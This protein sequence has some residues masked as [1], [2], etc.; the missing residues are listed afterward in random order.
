MA[1]KRPAKK[2]TGLQYTSAKDWA[3]KQ[4]SGDSGG[5]GASAITVPEGTTF[6]KLQ[7]S[8]EQPWVFLDILP[9]RVGAGNPYADEGMVHFER[10]YWRHFIPGADGGGRSAVCLARTFKEDCPICAHIQTLQ[11]SGHGEDKTTKGLFAKQRQLFNIMDAK[12]RSDG[13]V[14]WESSFHNFG[15]LLKKEMADPFSDRSGFFRLDTGSVV[16][17]RVEMHSYADNVKPYARID[18]IEFT[19]RSAPLPDT[20]LDK[21][22]CL[23]D[24]INHPTYDELAALISRPAA[25]AV[26][27]AVQAAPAELVGELE[28]DRAPDLELGDEFDVPFEADSDLTDEDEDREYDDISGD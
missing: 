20:L 16:R 21:V 15:A 23:D 22:L 4:Q 27:V 5:G 7:Y 26:P 2:T 24:L 11:R 13:L 10:T 18:K 3:V 6:Y 17:C 9:Y 25:V 8:S 28:G 12:N 19:E 14:L 1:K